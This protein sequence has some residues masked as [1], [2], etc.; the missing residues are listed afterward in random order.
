MP[1]AHHS[2]ATRRDLLQAAA[3]L[4]RPR[5]ARA[6]TA[7][8]APPLRHLARRWRRRRGHAAARLTRSAPVTTALASGSRCSTPATGGQQPLEDVVHGAGDDAMASDAPRET[9]LEAGGVENWLYDD[10][11]KAMPD[12]RSVSD[13]EFKKAAAG[14]C[15]RLVMIGVGGDVIRIASPLCDWH[16]TACEEATESPVHMDV[17]SLTSATSS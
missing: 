16:R 6:G 5:A 1:G 8:P 17:R 11:I 10:H 12:R 13:M 7:T 9:R 3:R 4:P 14:T 2:A 15:L